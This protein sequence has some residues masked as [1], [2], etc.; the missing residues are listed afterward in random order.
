MTRFAHIE[1]IAECC[2]AAVALLWRRNLS[3]TSVQKKLMIGVDAKTFRGDLE[4]RPDWALFSVFL[5]GV[6]ARGIFLP[7]PLSSEFGPCCLAH[8]SFDFGS[9]H[10]S[11]VR[12]GGA[13]KC[14]GMWTVA[15]LHCERTCPGMGRMIYAIVVS[16]LLGSTAALE[17]TDTWKEN[18]FV[19]VRSYIRAF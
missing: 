14:Q 2:K 19:H 4:L 11:K 13:K 3:L 7:C 16:A 18:R 8:S 17:L 1:Q 15:V 10:F 12:L 9:L 5:Q 6:F